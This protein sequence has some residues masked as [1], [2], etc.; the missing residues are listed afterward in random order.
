V[1]VCERERERE[2][3]DLTQYGGKKSIMQNNKF[4]YFVNKMYKTVSDD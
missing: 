1:C 3:L 2:R 4:S